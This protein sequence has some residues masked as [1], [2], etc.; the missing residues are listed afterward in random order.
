MRPRIFPDTK[1]VILTV[2]MVFHTFN[3]VAQ[4]LEGLLESLGIERENQRLENERK[5]N[6]RMKQD[7]EV[8]KCD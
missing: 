8:L 1:M 4:R 7:Y 5:F 6:S 2:S 3:F